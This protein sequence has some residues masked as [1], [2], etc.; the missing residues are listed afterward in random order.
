MTPPCSDYYSRHMK[1]PRLGNLNG[2][3][4]ADSASVAAAPD[5]PWLDAPASNK[6]SNS[7]NLERTRKTSGAHPGDQ[8]SVRPA[9]RRCKQRAPAKRGTKLP[10]TS[11]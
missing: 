4:A 3:A 7:C 9:G 10:G 6:A 11:C 5:A 2:A 1:S 8:R